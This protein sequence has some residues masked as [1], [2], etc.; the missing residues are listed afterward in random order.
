MC[1]NGKESRAKVAVFVSG[2]GSNLQAL[3]DASAS[4]ALSA[5]ISLVIS[6]RRKAFGVE[7]AATAGI[8][9]FVFKRKK[10]PTPEEA[11]LALARVLREHEIDYIALAGYLSL[12]PLPVLKRYQNKIVNI[13][14]APLPQFGGKG[15]YGSNVHEAVLS[16]G[17]ES[18]GPTVHIVDEIYD[19]GAVLAHQPVEVISGDT[20]E[21]LAARVLKAEHQ[22]YA[23]VLDKLIRGEYHLNHE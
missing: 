8:D 14:P 23:K 20:P 17:V 11:D 19:N 16:A 3:I 2:S 1:E 21:S 6:N 10:Y 15:M 12:I 5:D 22:L 9:T 7:R 4:G 18:S 13:H